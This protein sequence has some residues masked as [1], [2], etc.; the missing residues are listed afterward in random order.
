[1]KK[2]VV[3]L[4]ILSLIASIIGLAEARGVFNSRR[5]YRPPQ[6]VPPPSPPPAPAV[7]DYANLKII[8]PPTGGMYLG[9]Y[10]W[11]S[12]DIATF[13]AASG[14]KAALWSRYR[15]NW[16]IG[17]DAL[18]QPHLDLQVANQAWQEGKVLVVQAYNTHPSPDEAEAPR[19][20][21]VD[22][23]LAGQYDADLR[24]FAGE[25]RQYGKPV[26]FIV[27]REPN[28][29]DADYFGGFGPAGDKSLLWALQ[30]KRG[31]AEFNPSSLPYASLYTDIGAPQVCDGVERLKAAQRYY[32]DFFVRREGLKFLTFDTMGWAVNQVD[33]IEYDVLDLPSTVDK[34]YARELLKS[35]HSFANFYP[36]DAYVDWVSLNFYMVDYYAKDW[37]GLAQDYVIP[38][39]EHFTN[40]D[41]LMREVQATAPN[42]PVFFMEL[43]FPDGMNQNSNWAAQKISAGLS[44][45]LGSYPKISGFAM[46]SAH[47]AWTMAGVFPYDCLI[48]PGTQQGVALKS[49]I[50]ANTA[51][52]H[53][54]VYLS[55][56]KLQPNCSN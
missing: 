32:H 56:G 43:G 35:C 1:M 7:R 9:Q 33:Q 13:E 3:I 36:G 50:A 53:S 49:A 44:R 30:N 6:T 47:P 19:G 26:F 45:F 27:G 46:W 4:I 20:F 24:R 41:A 51:S 28:G 55:D 23:L 48:R 29:V 21:T 39:Q 52:F 40:L 34:A 17:Y 25:L 22:K 16:G 18:G 14:R 37:P 2:H 12:G 54:C 38:I 8:P 10:E 31:S 42:K 11:Q 5:P 15:G